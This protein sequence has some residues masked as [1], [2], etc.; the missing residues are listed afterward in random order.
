M[1]MALTPRNYQEALASLGDRLGP[2]SFSR[3]DLDMPPLPPGG[4]YPESRGCLACSD[5]PG[6]ALLGPTCSF[7]YVSSGISSP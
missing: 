1:E 7:K 4:G 3:T 6:T 2:C 5:L